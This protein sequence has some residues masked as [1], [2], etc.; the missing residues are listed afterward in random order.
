MRRKLLQSGKRRSIARRTDYIEA[1]SVFSLTENYQETVTCLYKLKR[2]I[3]V[4]RKLGLRRCPNTHIDLSKIEDLQPAA[5]VVLAAELDRWRRVLGV[6]LRPRN[7]RAWNKDVLSFL[8]DLGL[9]D[10]LEVKQHHVENVLKLKTEKTL[11]KVA[12]PFVSDCRNDKEP[13][14][15]LSDEL[16]KRVPKLRELLEEEGDMALSAA[17]AE[18]SLNSVQH[19]Y[20]HLKTKF[21]VVDDRWW[22]AASYQDNGKTVKFFVYDQGV[23]IPATLPKTT[24]GQ[25]ILKV[26]GKEV[27]A[28][29][30]LS[31][32]SNMIRHIL[33]MP[34]SSTGRR[35]RGKGFPQIVAAVTKKGGRLRVLSGA[36]GAIY[37]EVGGAEALPGSDLHLG[38]TLLEWTFRL[39]QM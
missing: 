23:G 18:A 16:S 29:N 32:H 10:L 11:R 1:P 2:S 24:V 36:G 28:V 12:L 3:L 13:T 17:L 22:A 15:Q 6:S 8:H 31:S 7:L 26:L 38:G 19:A 35:H 5:A 39:D 14:D 4:A 27:S 20:K 25:G 33:E 30:P 9:F 37:T 21:P 34:L